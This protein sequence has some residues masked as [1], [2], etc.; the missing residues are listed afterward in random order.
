MEKYRLLAVGVGLALF[1]ALRLVLS[2]TRI[3][4]LVRAGVENREMVEALGYRISILFVGVF[5]VASA[6]AGL[7]VIMWGLYD[8]V[9]TAQMGMSVMVLVF[10]TIIIGGLGSIEGCFLAALLIGLSNNYVAFLAPK[11]ALGSSLILMV[12]V[13]MW[14]PQGLLLPSGSR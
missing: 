2:R 14:R 13:L 1:V 10:I 4:L 7:G 5:V 12:A 9:I 6:L 8:E 11:L 3:G